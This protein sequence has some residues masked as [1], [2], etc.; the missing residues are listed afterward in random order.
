MKEGKIN[1][2]SRNAE[3]GSVKVKLNFDIPDEMM[4]MLLTDVKDAINKWQDRIIAVG[5]IK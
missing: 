5:Y 4:D 2:H 3:C 1:L